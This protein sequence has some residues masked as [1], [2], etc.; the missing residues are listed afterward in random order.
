[1]VLLLA[2]GA[3]LTNFQVDA[4]ATYLIPEAKHNPTV[5]RHVV[6]T[7]RLRFFSPSREAGRRYVDHLFAPD[8]TASAALV[9]L[10]RGRVA[11]LATAEL[12]SPE[13]A[14]VAFLVADE[15]RGRGL[16]SL[17]LEHLAH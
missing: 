1:M 6:D 5:A 16:G 10:V 2:P 17:L 13:A 3:L 7:L 11:G 4:H 15:D 8:N 12:L 14:E 9:A